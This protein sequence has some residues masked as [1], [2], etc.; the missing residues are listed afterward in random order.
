MLLIAPMSSPSSS[1]FDV[2]TTWLA[3]PMATPCAILFLTLN[4]L[5]MNGARMFPITPVNSSAVTVM[6]LIP[7]SD[8]DIAMA[9][10]V[11]TLFGMS[12]ERRVSSMPMADE[13]R[14]IVIIEAML[15][16]IV[17]AMIDGRCPSTSFLSL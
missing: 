1:A 2:P 9:I 7:P 6:D 8:C 10:G 17:P 4:S 15:P 12:D 11:V 3:V 13:S 5:I 14:M 16:A